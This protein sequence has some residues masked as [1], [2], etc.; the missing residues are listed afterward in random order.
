MKRLAFEQCDLMRQAVSRVGHAINSAVEYTAPVSN[1][2]SGIADEFNR[3]VFIGLACGGACR[4]PDTCGR[5]L[6]KS[7]RHP[8]TTGKAKIEALVGIAGFGWALP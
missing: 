6:Q 7:P 3:A 1:Y 2:C 4:F 8:Y 5:E